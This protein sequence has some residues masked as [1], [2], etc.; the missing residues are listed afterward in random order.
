MIEHEP[1][2]K[3]NGNEHKN[4][5]A[6]LAEVATSP[7]FYGNRRGMNFIKPS[8]DV[9]T[10]LL[11]SAAMYGDSVVEDEIQC[12]VVEEEMYTSVVCSH[13]N[14]SMVSGKAKSRKTF[15]V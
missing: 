4:A 11:N 13:G 7:A 3:L 10:E 14:I 12:V 2:K 15:L 1:I 8:E 6:K 5:E 9:L